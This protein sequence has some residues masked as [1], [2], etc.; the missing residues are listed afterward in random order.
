MKSSNVT[1]ALLLLLMQLL[2]APR[3]AT[4][5]RFYFRQIVLRRAGVV[6][7]QFHLNKSL[8]KSRSLHVASL[9]RR[10]TRKRFFCF[11]KLL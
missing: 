7:K 5:S 11:V 4:S 2:M 10:T 8:Q 1:S 9:T 6:S 3:H